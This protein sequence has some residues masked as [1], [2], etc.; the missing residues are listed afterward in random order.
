MSR[1]CHKTG[2]VAKTCGSE[3]LTPLEE[4]TQRVVTLERLAAAQHI[5]V[6]NVEEHMRR[7][8]LI[9]GA[10]GTMLSEVRRDEGQ[11]R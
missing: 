6:V 7:V 8:L 11:D 4:L 2:A 5:G 10:A 9:V 3:A 1:S